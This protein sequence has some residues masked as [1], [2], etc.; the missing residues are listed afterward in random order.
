MIGCMYMCEGAHM[1]LCTQ[2]GQRTPHLLPHLKQ[3]LLFPA[4]CPMLGGLRA[5]RDP[6]SLSHILS[7][8]HK[9]YRQVLPYPALCGI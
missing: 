2:G 4:A 8:E 9:D 7:Q 5:F 1:P 3:G 6:L